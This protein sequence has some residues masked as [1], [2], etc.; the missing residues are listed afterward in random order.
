MRN[1]LCDRFSLLDHV[2]WALTGRD[3]PPAL[4]DAYSKRRR[5]RFDA[6]ARLAGQTFARVASQLGSCVPPEL[7]LS[8]S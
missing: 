1:S 4:V 7:P 2:G 8:H 3:L 6:G 5:R